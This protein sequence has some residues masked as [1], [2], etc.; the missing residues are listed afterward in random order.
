MHRLWQLV[1]RAWAGE[2][3]LA[4]GVSR[5]TCPNCGCS[6]I[7]VPPGMRWQPLEHQAPKANPDQDEAGNIE[8]GA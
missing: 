4:S 1:R 3:I 2:T 7:S 5:Y 6:M 8:A